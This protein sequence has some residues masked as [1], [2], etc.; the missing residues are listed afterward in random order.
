MRANRALA[1]LLTVAGLTAV[2]GFA[3]DSKRDSEKDRKAAT[4]AVFGQIERLDTNKRM[5]FLG[6]AGGGGNQAERDRE[7][8]KDRAAKDRTP[9][10]RDARK[11]D[12]P[13]PNKVRV[14]TVGTDAKVTLDGKKASLSDLKTGHFARVYP[15]PSGGEGPGT[16][17]V[18]A[19]TKLPRDDRDRK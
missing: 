16:D 10:D 7:A 13:S 12:R 3:Q 17:R 2:A 15:S 11:R 19:F 5:L 4:P 8:E 6:D 1:A 14:Y 18:E 9:K